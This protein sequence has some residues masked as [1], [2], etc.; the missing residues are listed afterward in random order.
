MAFDPEWHRAYA[1]LELAAGQAAEAM[2]IAR[3]LTERKRP[4]AGAEAAYTAAVD[5]HRIAGA[6]R[7][8]MEMAA[9]VIVQEGGR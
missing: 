9:T 2:R 1:L 6:A 5:A 7:W 8:E 4:P 3:R